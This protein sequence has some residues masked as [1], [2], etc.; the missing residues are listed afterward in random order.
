M[1]NRFT[2][3]DPYS[4][5]GIVYSHL[6]CIETAIWTFNLLVPIEVH[7]LWKNPQMFSSKTLIYFR[8]TKE[9]HEYLG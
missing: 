4:S 9:R 6:S 2:R 5:A 7:Y 1:T 3:Q 8:L